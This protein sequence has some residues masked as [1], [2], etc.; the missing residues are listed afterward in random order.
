MRE[1]AICAA[2]YRARASKLR[3]EASQISPP[4]ERKRILGL[5]DECD[6]RAS[7][8]E[9]AIAFR[10][11]TIAGEPTN[12]LEKL[13]P[14][15]AHHE[16]GHAIA[17]WLGARSLDL[18][19]KNAGLISI[20]IPSASQLEVTFSGGAPPIGFCG[21]TTYDNAA[22]VK[23]NASQRSIGAALAVQALA[24]LVT[25]HR[26]L[27]EADARFTLTL[28]E[29]LAQTSDDQK[30]SRAEC[31][32]AFRAG[33]DVPDMDRMRWF[34]DIAGCTEP[35]IVSRASEYIRMPRAWRAIKAL[36]EALSRQNT[37]VGEEATR[38]IE[39]AWN[40]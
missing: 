28:R 21:T 25:E 10:F 2:L 27:R 4:R 14:L 19:I 38:I 17:L 8:L 1:D 40:S 16:A 39:S 6:W 33:H 32:A 29:Y 7:S 13:V 30:L 3:A 37:M 26:F 15:V 9:A 20:Q 31:D 22:W 11:G 23:S 5:A 12:A 24:G 18:S 36:A 35:Y 34:A